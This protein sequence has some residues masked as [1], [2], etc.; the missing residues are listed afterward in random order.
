MTLKHDFHKW[1]ISPCYGLIASLSHVSVIRA[2]L[3]AKVFPL[4]FCDSELVVITKD[5]VTL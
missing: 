4:V 3:K 5:V 2:D 1:D